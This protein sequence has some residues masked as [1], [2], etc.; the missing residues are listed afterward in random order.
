MP[1]IFLPTGVGAQYQKVS[2]YTTVDLHLGYAFQAEAGPLA[3]LSLALDVQNLLDEDP[4]LVL[5]GGAFPIRFDPANA[6]PYGRLVTLSL[7][8]AF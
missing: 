3:K 5:N 8:K 6:S 2:S 7:R 1:R 4:P